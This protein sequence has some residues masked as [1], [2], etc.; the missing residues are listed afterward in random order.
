MLIPVHRSL[1]TVGARNS[2]LWSPQRRKRYLIVPDCRLPISI[3]SR[4]TP[5]ATDQDPRAEVIDLIAT[6][7]LTSATAAVWT[8]WARF[9]EGAL[10]A[11]PAETDGWLSLGFDVCDEVFYSGL[12]N[13][14][15]DEQERPNLGAYWSFS[16]NEYHLFQRATDADSFRHLMDERVP[17]HAPFAV[18]QI[19]IARPGS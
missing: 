17:E 9:F 18:V 6:A 4:V 14:Q 7:H 3:D 19:F 5:A 11:S 15:L 10:K 8:G 12:M 16:L 2:D 1:R 13:C